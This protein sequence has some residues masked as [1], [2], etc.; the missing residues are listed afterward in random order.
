MIPVAKKGVGRW[1]KMDHFEINLCLV[2]P[3]IKIGKINCY[4]LDKNFR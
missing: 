4:L 3:A 2:L 1:I